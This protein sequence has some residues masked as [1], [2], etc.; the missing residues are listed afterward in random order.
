MLSLV[1]ILL[2]MYGAI[3][4]PMIVTNIATNIDINTACAKNREALLSLFSPNAFAI[5]EVVPILIPTPRAIMIK[6]I[7]NV[8]AIAA[9]ASADI[10]PAKKVS[11]KL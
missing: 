7:G 11:T 3:F 6:Y 1:F 10:F 4:I 8:C 5:K 2:I 9:R